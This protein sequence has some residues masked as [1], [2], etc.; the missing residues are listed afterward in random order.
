MTGETKRRNQAKLK[1]NILLRLFTY[2]RIKPVM[3]KAKVAGARR[4][5]QW[6]MGIAVWVRYRF[7]GIANKNIYENTT[8]RKFSMLKK[9][10]RVKNPCLVNGIC[11]ATNLEYKYRHVENIINDRKRPFLL[12]SPL[13]KKHN[14]A[15]PRG[16]SN[17][18]SRENKAKRE[19]KTARG[20]YSFCFFGDLNARRNNKNVARIKTPANRSARP[21]M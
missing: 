11:R 4:S 19:D 18:L 12:L 15:I 21:D 16:R 17:A 10:S 5:C 14:K 6:N 8:C 2:H 13:T 9:G 7:T 20:K 3:A 1:F